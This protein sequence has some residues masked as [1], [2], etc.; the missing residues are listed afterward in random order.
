MTN[1]TIFSYFNLILV[2]PVQQV[3]AVVA[4]K[5]GRPGHA[6]PARKS[7]FFIVLP[8]RFTYNV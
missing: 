6:V 1:L 3:M 2:V 7:T 4:V 5:H 8:C